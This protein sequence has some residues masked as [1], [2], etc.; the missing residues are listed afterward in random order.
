MKKAIQVIIVLLFAAGLIVV[1]RSGLGAQ[2][3]LE[4][5]PQLRDKILSFGSW[6]VLA[7][8]C[9]YVLVALFALPGLPV[10]ILGAIIYGPLWGTIYTVL[11]ASVGLALAFL[12]SRYLVRDFVT[13]KFEHTEAFRKINEGVSKEGWRILMVTRLVPVFP[14]SIQNYVYGLT[15]FNFFSYWVLS[16]LFII[17][18]TAAY[19]LSAGA[20]LSG[21]FS[22]ANTL[23]L[24]LGVLCFVALSFIPKFIKSKSS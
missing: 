20:V 10:T 1:L 12:A 11:S 19:T 14:F 18:G 23:Y 22:S 5:L 9:L 4:K 17:P 16:T 6:S 8:F 2:L 15:S 7:F 3:S 21:T 13:A 24:A